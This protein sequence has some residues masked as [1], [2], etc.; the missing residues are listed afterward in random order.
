MKQLTEIL[1][2]CPLVAILR[3]V[4]PGEVVAIGE[5]LFDAGIRVLEVPLNSPEPLES[6]HRLS[7]RCGDRM[8]VGAGTVLHVEDV[9]LVANAGG[10]LAVMPNAESDVVRE[11]KRLG[12]LAIP[13]I[14]TPTEAFAMLR[15]GAD[16]LKF[17]P[18]DA[19]SDEFPEF[20]ARG[21]AAGC[22]GP[23]GWRHSC[24][25]PGRVAGCGRVGIRHRLGA[26]QTG[27]DARGSR[28]AR[29]RVHA[30]DR[31]SWRKRLRR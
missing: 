1:A 23:A 8:L 17:F 5:A 3:G 28:S 25:K 22:A 11:A 2:E 29:N 7:G 9:Q 21:A 24:G 6:I 18:A 30:G 10:R 12:L 31:G 26:L 27:N 20:F 16:A 19:V 4:Q 15:A 13:G 14:F